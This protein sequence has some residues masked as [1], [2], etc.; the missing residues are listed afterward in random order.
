[1]I[2]RN[3]WI[4][5]LVSHI[6]LTGT[7]LAF[8]LVRNAGMVLSFAVANRISAHSSAQD[9]NAPNNEIARPTLISNAPQGPTICSSTAANEGFC[10]FAS[11]GWVMIPSD[12]TF[13]STSSANT[14]MN[15][16]TVARPTSERF[17]ARAE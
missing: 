11:S 4:I 14:P 5:E 12:N 15:P 17:S 16:I 3:N 10:S 8:S 7:R 2:S 9:S 13:T 6:A 1:M